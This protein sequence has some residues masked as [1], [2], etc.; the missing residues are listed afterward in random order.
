MAIAGIVVSGTMV[1]SVGPTGLSLPEVD[2]YE[3]LRDATRSKHLRSRHVP[4]Y[5][6]EAGPRRTRG[7]EGATL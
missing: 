4:R 6:T 3:E 5:L 2:L 1:A 7:V